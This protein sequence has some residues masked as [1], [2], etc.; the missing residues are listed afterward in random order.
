MP[1]T[2][3]DICGT[4]YFCGSSKDKPMQHTIDRGVEMKHTFFTAYDVWSN[5]SNRAYKI[6]GS[7]PDSKTYYE[8]TK[9]LDPSKRLFYVFTLKNTEV[10]C[11][12]DLEWKLDWKSIEDIKGYI[13]ERVVSV[14]EKIDIK[15]DPADILF[16]NA[17]DEKKNKGSLHLHIPAVSFKNMIEQQRFWNAVNLSISSEYYFHEFSDKSVI[18]KNFL[19][20]GV[21]NKKR[22]FRLPYSCKLKSGK[23]VRPLIPEDEKNFDITQWT[24]SDLNH[25]KHKACVECLPDNMTINRRNLIP[26]SML[27][28]ML[29]EAKLDRDVVIADFAQGGKFVHLRNRTDCRKCPI[30]GE[31]NLSDNAYLMIRG[32]NVH[33]GCHDAGCKG[34]SRIIGRLDGYDM[35]S[36]EPPFKRYYYK[37]LSY[38]EKKEKWDAYLKEKHKLDAKREKNPDATYQ[39]LIAPIEPVWSVTDMIKDLN[40]YCK[41]VTGNCKVVVIYR[42]VRQEKVGDRIFDQVVWKEKNPQDF[43][44]TF[45][46]GHLKAKYTPMVGPLAWLRSPSAERYQHYEESPIVGNFIPRGTFSTFTNIMITK[47]RAI[48]H[49]TEKGQREVEALLDFFKRVWCQDNEELFKYLICWL[50]W[51]VQFPGKKL[52]TSIV[53]RGKEG[54]GKSMIAAIMFQILGNHYCVAPDA[55]QVFDKF[56]SMLDGKLFCF[57]DEMTW[58]GDKS[59]AGILKKLL[60]ENTRVSQ[61]KFGLIR[62]VKN[63]MNFMIASNEDWV[64]PAGSG[65]R[66]YTVFETT[67]WLKSQNRQV[68]KGLAETCPFSFAKYL[69]SV[70]L[71]EFNGNVNIKTDALRSQVMR[72][73]NPIHE[74]LLEFAESGRPLKCID[75]LELYGEYKNDCRRPVNYGVF[76]NTVKK[77]AKI[78]SYKKQKNGIRRSVLDFEEDRTSLRTRVSEYYNLQ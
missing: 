43:I 52:H 60:T 21:Y 31:D 30:G 28:N 59:K 47:K 24:I 70:D 67:D 73:M 42:V 49:A 78:K 74:F 72:S 66:R 27:N 58:G 54:T 62:T 25:V 5:Q 44:Q 50:A 41:L 33:Y 10:C 2:E 51:Q 6:F 9:K 39:E 61:R 55:L 57:M 13:S 32:R 7:Y 40:Q 22:Q 53:V 48:L 19:D 46:F 64:I 11:F 75:K 34:K 56:N 68:R 15:I 63:L 14:F 65:A 12:A 4:P 36:P 38:I 1:I 3:I 37:F 35:L 26:I 76:W 20:G 18:Y 29:K 71:S 23:G 8:Q 77:V 16:S 45:T 17:S 69:Y